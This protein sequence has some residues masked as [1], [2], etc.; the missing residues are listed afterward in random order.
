MILSES[1]VSIRFLIF[2]MLMFNGIRSIQ[3]IFQQWMYRHPNITDIQYD[4]VMYSFARG[5]KSAVVRFGLAN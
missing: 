4:R 5:E 2:E 1:Q 3:K